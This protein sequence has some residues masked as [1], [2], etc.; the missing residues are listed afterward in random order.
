MVWRTAWLFD[1]SISLETKTQPN[2]GGE[3]AYERT[4]GQDIDSGFYC[5][6]CGNMVRPGDFCLK[7][8]Q[9][10]KHCDCRV[11]LVQCSVCLELVAQDELCSCCKAC[12]KCRVCEIEKNQ[13]RG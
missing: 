5:H 11:S 9:C 10:K 13:A 8:N 2:K 4:L 12:S 3:M 1:L 6:N 7:C